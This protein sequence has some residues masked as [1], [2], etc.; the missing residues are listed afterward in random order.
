MLWLRGNS[1]RE[2][3]KYRK[4]REH[5][6]FRRIISWEQEGLTWQA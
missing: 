3:E 2:V 1:V 4:V 5:I 6:L